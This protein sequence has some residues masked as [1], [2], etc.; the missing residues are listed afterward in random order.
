MS[1]LATGLASPMPSALS[2][3]AG[4][5][6]ATRSATTACARRSESFLVVGLGTHRVGVADDGR[7]GLVVLLQ[8]VGELGQDRVEAGLDVG[9]VEGEQHLVLQRYLEEV[10]PDPL[11]LDL[12]L[13]LLGGERVIERLLLA[14]E[15]VARPAAD[16][17]TGCGA[18]QGARA[19]MVLVQ[20]GTEQT[21]RH[22]AHAGADACV[23]VGR[24]LLAGLGRCAAG[25]QRGTDQQGNRN[26]AH[27][28][29]PGRHH[30][31]T[32]K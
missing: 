26:M 18:D 3:E 4:T 5:P 6:L 20:N 17:T 11:D 9:L 13:A 2:R 29:A 27:G 25:K 23:L 24:A 19:A 10:V 21:A 22:G 14:V 30:S 7:I 31:A 8:H 32:E 15:Q 16:G 1:L 12:V 28:G